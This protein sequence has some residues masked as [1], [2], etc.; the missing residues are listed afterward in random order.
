MIY[1]YYKEQNKRNYIRRLV[2]ILTLVSLFMVLGLFFSIFTEYIQIYEIGKRFTSVFWINFNVKLVVQLSSFL[3][4]FFIFF[5]STIIIRANMLARDPSHEI[6]KRIMPILLLSF[7]I[8]FVASTFIRDTVYNRFL[9]FANALPFNKTDPIFNQDIGYYIF[10]RPFLISLV[11]SILGVWIFQTLYTF[12]LYIIFYSGIGFRSTSDIIHEKGIVLHNLINIIVLFLIKASTYRFESESILYSTIGE[13]VGAGYTDINVWLRYYR[14]AP[15]LLIAI[16][17]TTII[18]LF[19]AKIKYSILTIAIFPVAWIIVLFIAGMV[20][21]LIVSPNEVAVEQP[22]LKH[23]IDYTRAAYNLENII[24]KEFPLKNDLTMQD[25]AQNRV[26]IDNIRITDFPATL[27]VLNQ[28]Q[29]IRNYYRF[30]DTDIATYNINGSPTAVFIGARELYKENLDESAKTYINK[31]FRFTH[32]FGVVMNPINKIT[33][34]GHPDFIIKNIPPKSAD[35]VPQVA[36]PRIYF[37]ELTNDYVIVNAKNQ[38]ELD[39]SE[40]QDDVEFVYDGKAGI[41]L[42]FINRMIFSLKYGD[43]RMLVS[44]YITPESKILLN[45]NILKRVQRVAPFLEYDDDPYIVITEDGKL[46]W[47]IDIYTT[48]NYYPYSQPIGNINYIRNSAKAV[49]DAYDGTVEFYIT[50][51]SDPIINV[52][53]NIYPDLF[54]KDKLPEDM[55]QHIRYPEQL[56]KIQ[57]QIFR[58]YHMTNPVAFY[59]K[60]DLWE[61]SQEKYRGQSK[62]VDPYYNLMKLPDISTREELILMIPY[63][64]VKKENMV[65][66]LAVRSEGDSYG[67]MVLYKFPKGI[68]VYGT[69]QIENRIDSNPDISRELSLWD[70]GGSS[71]IRGNLLVIPINNS[72]LYVEPIY[73]T[74]ANESSLPEVKRIV[75][76]YGDQIVMEPTLERALNVLFGGAQPVVPSKGESVKDIIEKALKTFQDVKAYTRENDWEN[77]GKAFKQ[78]DDIMD[79]LQERKTEIQ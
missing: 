23:N 43:L 19:R 72:L 79:I 60:A 45:R 30:T 14:I 53:N 22:Y 8:S 39:Y 48:S 69:M 41:K 42:N 17:I 59:N 9:L 18:L 15:I 7:I 35:G 63:T 5:I 47:I 65:S 62:N 6:L 1:D 51:R 11:E 21:T 27:T 66:W 78:L 24:E 13:V 31:K 38:K 25:I 2:V 4:V 49:V 26:T 32:G 37:G 40:G 77:F 74:A 3:I 16:V 76:A 10:Q 46:K 20:Q 34:Q 67:Q 56:F 68:N 57:A 55:A 29:G 52:Y 73:I 50:D 44:G 54:N 71:V 64:L 12:I 61:I 28:L 36:Q 58:K 33:E 70:Q 75:V